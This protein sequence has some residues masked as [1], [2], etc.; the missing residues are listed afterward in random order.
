MT[1]IP[2]EDDM[3]KD[4]IFCEMIHD[5]KTERKNRPKGEVIGA[6]VINYARYSFYAD[7]FS[8]I[9]D[10]GINTTSKSSYNDV[11]HCSSDNVEDVLLRY[12]ANTGSENLQDF[13]KK[14]VT[15]LGTVD[16]QI[17]T[18]ATK[19]KGGFSYNVMGIEK[20]KIK[21]GK[22]LYEIIMS[23]PSTTGAQGKPIFLVDTGDIIRDLKKGKAEPTTEAYIFSPLVTM[24][25]PA[26][27]LDPIDGLSTSNNKI[28]FATSNKQ[29]G[30]TKINFTGI[31]LNNVYSTSDYTVNQGQGSGFFSN[32]QIKTTY[33]SS[34]KKVKQEWTYNGP[35]GDGPPHGYKY[36][37][38]AITYE[39]YADSKT[40]NKTSF[41]NTLNS[42]TF[43]PADILNSQPNCF[44]FIRQYINE[45]E[46]TP[47]VPAIPP[48]FGYPG[49]LRWLQNHNRIMHHD[50]DDNR[51][52]L[53]LALQRKRAGDW[54]PVSYILDYDTINLSQILTQKNWDNSAPKAQK[55]AETQLG[56]ASFK[57][58]D[59]YIVTI[60]RPLVAYC[61]F[62]GV[63]VIYY[64]NN[65]GPVVFKR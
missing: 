51:V 64:M 11:L 30:K 25:D 27:G 19:T 12:I 57:A 35:I 24:C 37:T 10:S 2:D 34:L 23:K 47:P 21:S 7:R 49:N 1:T 36:Q 32:F 58:K 29:I 56:S 28:R 14:Q 41:S 63:N 33:D 31:R 65:F 39:W 46:A 53:A 17:T 59:M 60:D 15:A 42:H 13:I 3:L 6:D 55:V 40:V 38:N 43:K 5:F 61:L 62:R 44:N 22:K 48:K 16:T 45:I 52:A 18:R 20:N 54:L 8:Q 9:L 4:F 50:V 26:G